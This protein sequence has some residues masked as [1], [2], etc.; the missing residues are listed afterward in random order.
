MALTAEQ[1]KAREG[2]LTASRVACLMEGDEAKIL[3][4]WREL[5]GDPAFVPEDYTQ[6]W[7]VRLGSAT[8][9][10][11]LEWIERKRGKVSRRGDVALHKDHDWAAATL[12]GWLDSHQCPV[13][14]K[15]VGG[16]EKLETV[17]QRYMP[18]CHWQMLVTGSPQCLFSVIEGAREPVSEFIVL[19]KQYGDEL[20]ARATTFMK[21][22]RSLTPPVDLPEI[23]APVK[24]IKEY[25]YSTNNAFVS[26]AADWLTNKAAAKAFDDATVTIKDLCPRDAIKVH[27]GGVVVNRDR[28]NRLK[29]VG[30]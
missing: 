21:Y 10:L 15:H 24:A 14:C 11:H 2:K 4:L 16:F 28:A 17:I 13:E 18:Q 3:N 19:D 1:L 7:P 20:M 25:D 29:I 26:A 30:K 6:V 8:E 12:D 22:V 27:G 9:D 23:L 5:V